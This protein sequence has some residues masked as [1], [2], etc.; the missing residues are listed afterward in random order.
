MIIAFCNGKGGAGKTTL[1]VLLGC[2]LADAGRRVGLLDRD[3]QRTATRWIQ[4]TKSPITP[5]SCTRRRSSA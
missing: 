1:S 3:P 5:G 4:E 2:A